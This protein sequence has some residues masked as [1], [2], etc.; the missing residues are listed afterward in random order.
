VTAFLIPNPEGASREEIL[1][2]PER[3]EDAFWAHAAF[4][5]FE[6]PERIPKD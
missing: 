2:M 4:D 3:D 6:L 5:R 1:R